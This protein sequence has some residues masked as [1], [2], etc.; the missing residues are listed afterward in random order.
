VQLGVSDRLLAHRFPERWFG[1]ANAIVHDEY[2]RG[3]KHDIALL[4]LDRHVVFIR[5]RG[6][7][8]MSLIVQV[9]TLSCY[10]LPVHL[11]L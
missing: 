11:S 7:S 1:V 9:H 3:K 10:F 4:R 2:V 5:V 8:R 6:L